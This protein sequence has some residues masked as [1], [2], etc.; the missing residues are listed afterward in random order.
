[1]KALI[2]G[3]SIEDLRKRPCRREKARADSRA[4]ARPK[5]TMACRRG[6]RVSTDSKTHRIPSTASPAHA[7]FPSVLGPGSAWGASSTLNIKS[8]SIASRSTSQTPGETSSGSPG[9]LEPKPRRMSAVQRQPRRSSRRPRRRGQLLVRLPPQSTP[10][11]QS[12]AQSQRL[13]LRP[14]KWTW[15]MKKWGRFRQ[16]EC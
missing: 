8:I 16:R 14:L 11:L 5:A 10:Q 3:V 12:R 4:V 6:G 7:D 15:M 2:R 13:V 1:M 9:T